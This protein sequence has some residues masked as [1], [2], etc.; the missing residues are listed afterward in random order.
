MQSAQP[1]LCPHSSIHS[2]IHHSTRYPPSYTPTSHTPCPSSTL[3]STT[4]PLLPPLPINHHA[5]I[6]PTFR[7]FIHPFIHLP[8]SPSS[9][10][11]F[12]CSLT[13]HAPLSIHLCIYLCEHPPTHDSFSIAENLSI[14][15]HIERSFIVHLLCTRHSPGDTPVPLQ[16][17]IPPSGA[18]HTF[19]PPDHQWHPTQ[20][21]LLW[22]GQKHW[23]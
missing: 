2:S 16:L 18:L 10:L 8:I 7:S 14:H 1:P 22:E 19:F 23:K 12:I 3:V 17:Q 5:P 21:S 4:Q 20:C 11:L 6:Y 13:H 9:I 15:V